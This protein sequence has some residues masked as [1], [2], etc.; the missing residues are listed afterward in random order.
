[1]ARRF[2]DPFG[3]A[4]SIDYDADDLLPTT[5]TDSASNVV[6]ASNDYR[7]LAPVLI[8]DP[9]RN[10]GAVSFDTLG[11]VAGTAVMGKATENLGDS[12]ATFT[13]DLT[14][15][16]IEGFFAANDPHTLANDL[17]GT[18]TTR[19]IY[20]V[21]RFLTTSQAAP[22]DPTQWMPIFAATLA[23]ETHLSDLTANQQ[24]KIQISFSYSDGF[25]RE[26]QKEDNKRNLDR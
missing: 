13:P 1:M 10:R 18:A 23:R 2:V 22:N 4:A 12:L 3:D 24:T 7:V 6:S 5:T 11:M 14:Q 8:T 25:A 9:N 15:A 17:L 20:D 21:Q 19:I 26:I 16:Q